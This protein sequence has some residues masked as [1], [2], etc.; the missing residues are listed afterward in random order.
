VEAITAYTTVAE[1]LKQVRK[2][3]RDEDDAKMAKRIKK[4]KDQRVWAIEQVIES[5]RQAD[6]PVRVKKVKKTKKRYIISIRLPWE[7]FDKINIKR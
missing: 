1:E 2:R 3:I 5:N 7:A 6:E 4:N